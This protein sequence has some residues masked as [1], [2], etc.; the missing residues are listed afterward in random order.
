MAELHYP[1]KVELVG[2]WLI[3]AEQLEALDEVVDR[4]AVAL[5]TS[6]DARLANYLD[7]YIARHFES[8][9]V[10]QREKIRAERRSDW[11]KSGSYEVKRELRVSLQDHKRLSAS[12][13][14]EASRHPEIAASRIVELEMELGNGETRCSLS[15]GGRWNDN[16]LRLS[17][18][19]DNQ[20]DRESLFFA[21]RKWVSDCQAP[22]WQRAWNWTASHWT[23]WF[24]WWALVVSFFL[25]D[26]LVKSGDSPYVDAAHK[27][28][29]KGIDSKDI[30]K[31]LEF[32]LALESGYGIRSSPSG[33]PILFLLVAVGGL[34][35]CIALSIHPHFEV[36]LGKGRSRLRFWNWWTRCVA[37]SLP[38]FVLSTVAENFI[39]EI[40]RKI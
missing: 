28:L 13:F 39:S 22:G 37:V 17:V 3:T 15:I 7:D 9:Q 21:L 32:I 11:Q 33:N 40:I 36:G 34:L 14:K 30:T 20:Q 5:Q 26:L 25:K 24:I 27:L 29:A 1:T 8:Y 4:E 12:T 38:I 31:A 23:Q 2:P 6:A 16:N 35:V 19:G 10:E 18:S